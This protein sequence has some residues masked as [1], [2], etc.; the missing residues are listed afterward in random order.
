MPDL[1]RAAS[2]GISAV[3]ISSCVLLSIPAELDSGA[4]RVRAG[5]G[6]D[7][8]AAGADLG[9]EGT[10]AAAVPFCAVGICVGWEVS[11]AGP[12]LRELAI[13]SRSDGACSICAAALSKHRH[14]TLSFVETEAHAVS[15][16]C[17]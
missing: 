8:A 5:L 2:Q 7:D 11:A 15:P 4:C 14:I 6:A 12:W 10:G 17:R 16:S 9:P 1:G 13:F 3:Y